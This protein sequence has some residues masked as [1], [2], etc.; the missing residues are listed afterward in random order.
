MLKHTADPPRVG[1]GLPESVADEPRPV[2]EAEVTTKVNTPNSSP[3]SVVG[4]RRPP[5]L[6]TEPTRTQPKRNA[7]RPRRFLMTVRND[8]ISGPGEGRLQ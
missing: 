8:G 4:L 7:P 6:S 5:A 2:G 3:P 1:G